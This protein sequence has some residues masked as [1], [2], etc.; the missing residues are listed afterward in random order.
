MKQFLLFAGTESARADGVNG[1]VGDFDT[2]AD[3]FL[4]LVDCQTPSQWWHVLDTQTGEVIERR[5]IRT[6]NGMIGFQRS[7]RIVGTQAKKLPISAPASA[8]TQKTVDHLNGLEADMRAVVTNGAK[9]GNGHANGHANGASA[10][11]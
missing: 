6:S 7:D 11:S 3:A 9:H 10:E 8:A 2:A 4:S 5:H 1:F